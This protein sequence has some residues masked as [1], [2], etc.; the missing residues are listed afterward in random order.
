MQRNNDKKITKKATKSKAE[1]EQ[2]LAL[3]AQLFLLQK[4]EK[5][6]KNRKSNK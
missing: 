2:H 1:N 5:I 6:K 3:N 4:A